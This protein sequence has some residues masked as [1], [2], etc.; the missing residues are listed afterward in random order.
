[1]NEEEI[2]LKDFTTEEKNGYS[3]LF[4]IFF[5]LQTLTLVLTGYNNKTI[6][7]FL[8][9]L[10]AFVF[11]AISFGFSY[12]IT[13]IGLSVVLLIALFIFVYYLVK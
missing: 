13:L 12:V 9:F 1:M 3:T 5:C 8:Q 4:F 11:L 10:L 6:S 7:M 2:I